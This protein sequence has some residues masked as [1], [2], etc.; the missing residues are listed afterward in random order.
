MFCERERRRMI[1]EDVSSRDEDGW[2]GVL[3][4]KEECGVRMRKFYTSWALKEAYIKMVGE[5]LLAPWLRE[6]EFE[7]VPVVPAPLVK[8]QIERD[9]ELIALGMSESEAD[10][11]TEVRRER[12]KWAGVRKEAIKSLKVVF[13]GRDISAQMRTELDGFEDRFLIAT[14]MRGLKEEKLEGVERW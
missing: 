5:G 2:E 8:E 13:K 9:V 7:G 1:D 12:E 10:E 4:E 14:M 6:L 3:S 11:K